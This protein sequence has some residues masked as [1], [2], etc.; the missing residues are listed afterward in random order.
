MATLS[1]NMNMMAIQLGAKS[2]EEEDTKSVSD[3]KMGVNAKN[4]ALTKNPENEKEWCQTLSTGC[5]NLWG[6]IC[7]IVTVKLLDS[8]VNHKIQVELDSH[9]DTSIVGSN[10][11]VVHGHEY[12]VDVYGYNSKSRHKH[13]TT[14]NAAVAYNNPQ[15]GDT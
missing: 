13:V 8:S 1:K 3:V 14:I 15:T 7:P 5:I 12:S 4:P 2:G 10:V 6:N 11:L 9:A